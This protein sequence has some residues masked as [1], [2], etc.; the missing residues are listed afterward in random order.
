MGRT[1]SVFGCVAKRLLLESVKLH[2]GEFRTTPV[3][4][5]TKS[6]GRDSNDV[7]VHGFLPSLVR[8][9]YS[10]CGLRILRP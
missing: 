2:L 6:A 8:L 5:E 1:M 4:S 10:F 9:N 3:S 7:A